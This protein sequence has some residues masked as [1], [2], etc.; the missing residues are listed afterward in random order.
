MAGDTIII[1]EFMVKNT[2]KPKMTSGYFGRAWTVLLS[3]MISNKKVE[4]FADA[5]W[6]LNCYKDSP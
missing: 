2:R 4:L 6:G 5:T 3:I 1:K